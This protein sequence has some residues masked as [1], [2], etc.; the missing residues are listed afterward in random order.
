MMGAS[1]S[2]PSLSTLLSQ[3]LV[4]FTIELDN[5]FEHRMPHWTTCSASAPE[6]AIRSKRGREPRQGP[7]LVS[8]AMYLNCMRWL[9]EDGVSVAELE[10]VARTATNLD[11]M[12]RW[13][14]VTIDP[15]PAPGARRQTPSQA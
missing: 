12:R 6:A 14:Y 9:G 13:R 10:R 3:A 11:G 5:E 15:A 4:A 7:W 2:E 8:L 1:R